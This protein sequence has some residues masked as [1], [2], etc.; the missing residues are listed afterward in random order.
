METSNVRIDR[1]RDRSLSVPAA[2]LGAG[3]RHGQSGPVLTPSPSCLPGA[4]RL[5]QATVLYFPKVFGRLF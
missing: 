5:I 1:G 4:L 3:G 2:Q